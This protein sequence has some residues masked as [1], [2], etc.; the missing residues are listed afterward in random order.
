MNSIYT[1]RSI[2]KY[3]KRPVE[4]QKIRELLKASMCA[5]SAGNEQPWHFI[6]LDD[7][8]LISRIPEFHPYAAMVEEASHVVCVCADLNLQLYEGYWV[9][10]CSAATQNMLLMAEEL[11]IGSVWLGVY[12]REE[13][14]EGVSR[15]LKLPGNIVPFSLVALGY[16]AESK[17]ANDKYFEERIHRNLW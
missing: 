16:P 8:K 9:Q 13:R 7:R 10:D 3:Q 4:E 15:L 17:P 5:P 1:R 14:M 12:P 2:R 11:G 6:V